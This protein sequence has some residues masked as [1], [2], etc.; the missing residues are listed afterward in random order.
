MSKQ[1]SEAGSYKCDSCNIYYEVKRENCIRCGNKYDLN[2]ARSVSKEA[3]LEYTRLRRFDYVE[4]SALSAYNVD[5]LFYHAS[6]L[7]HQFSD[8]TLKFRE[9]YSL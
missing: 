9:E 2:E 6:R 8:E 7:S 1:N 3:A 4:T 5:K